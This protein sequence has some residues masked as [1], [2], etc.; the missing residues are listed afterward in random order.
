MKSRLTFVSLALCLLSPWGASQAEDISDLELFR[1]QLSAVVNPAN[2][3]HLS[4]S[5]IPNLYEVGVGARVIYI[6][7]D[8]EYMIRGDM[9]N[10][11]TGDNL[12]EKTKQ[13]ISKGI[14][15][16]VKAEDSV[17]FAAKGD[18]PKHTITVF[19]D[20]ECPYC[21][22]LHNE[23]PALNDAGVEVRYLFFPRRGVNSQAFSAATGVWCADNQQAAMTEAKRSG[24][25]PAGTCET[26]V[27]EHMDLVRKLR[28]NGTPAIF[29]AEGQHIP[30]Y[31]PAPKL[32]EMLNE[33]PAG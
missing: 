5:A 11:R 17:V 26:P 20:I 27:L 30:G 16:D 6:S 10:L 3:T 33:D 12:S 14:L 13:G 8:M 19:T 31:V 22:K 21:E 1:A 23:V 2:I 15:A 4:E 32:L 25:Y 18:K 9:V 28:I 24:S 29:T 7:A